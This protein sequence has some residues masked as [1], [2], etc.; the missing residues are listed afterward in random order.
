M[1]DDVGSRSIGLRIGV[2]RDAIDSG[3]LVI[4][5]AGGK[6]GYRAAA[7]AYPFRFREEDADEAINCACAR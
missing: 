6:D 5:L 2:Q 1:F 4:A 7:S 3:R